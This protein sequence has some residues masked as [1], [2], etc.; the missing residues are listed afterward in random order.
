M[1][2]I[3]EWALHGLHDVVWQ[4]LVDNISCS[5]KGICRILD[6]GAGPGE[7]TTRIMD[8]GHVA[9][10]CDVDKSNFVGRCDKFI[11]CD[12]NHNWAD[13][14]MREGP[15][16][17]VVAQEV[18]EHI[19][20]PARF[21]RDIGSVLKPDG[22]C[23]LT[24]PNNQDKASRVDFLFHGE[25]PWF[26]IAKVSDSGHQTPIF[27]EGFYLMAITAGFDLQGY[28]GYG[29]RGPLKLNWKGRIFE[30]YLDRKM[31]GACLNNVINIWVLQ[32]NGD[33]QLKGKNYYDSNVL[34]KAK[35]WIK[36]PCA[37]LNAKAIE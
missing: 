17:V 6:I 15:Y 21:M 13:A 31:K 23:L 2:I 4:L 24:S 18:I 8:A 25:L 20:N 34:D 37:I 30:R 28:Y 1:K 11:I 10:A 14:V 5:K 22:L 3:P 33:N 29:E 7:F 35:G 32:M 19:E 27:L 9:I 12:L 26:R 16:D 36:R